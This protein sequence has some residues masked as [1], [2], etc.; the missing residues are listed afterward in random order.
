MAAKWTPPAEILDG[1]IVW[2]ICVVK[3]IPPEHL[4]DEEIS[5]TVAITVEDESRVYLLESLSPSRMR[6]SLAHELVHV[7]HCGMRHHKQDENEEW[8]D[9][10]ATGL[11]RIL[12]G[13]PPIFPQARKP[14]AKKKDLIP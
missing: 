1:P 3:E 9:D 10:F 12:E 13:N 8:V 6:Q 7:I 2:Q 11:Q 5:K 4:E 14:R